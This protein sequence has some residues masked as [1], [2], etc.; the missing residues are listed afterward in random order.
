M[1]VPTLVGAASGADARRVA[2]A[3]IGA[4]ARANLV[5]GVMLWYC[6]FY[7]N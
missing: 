4:G 6:Y 5:K 1:L 3:A 7:L 2:G